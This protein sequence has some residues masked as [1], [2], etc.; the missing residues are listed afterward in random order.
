MQLDRGRDRKNVRRCRT[1][2]QDEISKSYFQ[3]E[4]SEK[5]RKFLFR[6][7][8]FAIALCFCF[9]TKLFRIDIDL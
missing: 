8:L 3:F 7:F 4:G 9:L 6:C 5:S 1:E 2:I